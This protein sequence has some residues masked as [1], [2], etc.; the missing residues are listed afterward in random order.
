M[1]G[2]SFSTNFF[3]SSILIGISWSESFPN[4][5]ENCL[6]IL[7]NSKLDDN[8]ISLRAAGLISYILQCIN[9]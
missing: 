8:K 7:C 6:T 5:T 3:K 1:T 4:S 2:G 9:I